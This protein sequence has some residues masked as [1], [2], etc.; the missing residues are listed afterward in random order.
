M[1]SHCG[2]SLRCPV[3]AFCLWLVALLPN[4]MPSHCGLS[5]CSQIPCFSLWLVALLPNPM[6]CQFGFSSFSSATCPPTVAWPFAAPSTPSVCSLSSCS[7]IPCSFT[8]AC[9][10]APKSHALSMWLVALPP[11]P[12]PFHC[13]LS[14]CSQIPCPL[15]VACRPAPKS[16]ALS[17]WL[18]ALPPNPMLFSV[19][20]RP[21][22]KFH[23]FLCGL[24]P[25]LLIPYCINLACHHAH[26][27][28]ALSLWLVT[29]LPNFFLF[30]SL[31]DADSTRSTQ[32]LHLTFICN[33]SRKSFIRWKN[34][35]FFC[36]LF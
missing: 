5:P 9:R 14:P 17:L 26:Q 18:V 15:N 32:F 19:A 36:S 23:A 1:P 4:P 21:A 25:C 12:M 22:P 20:C 31:T 35:K 28:H 7:Q 29:F 11:N 10:P 2:L 3:H 13:G 6:L 16:H 30:P 33:N 34:H 24:S 8:V 27:P